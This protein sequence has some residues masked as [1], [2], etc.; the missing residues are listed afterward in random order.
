MR[1]HVD[2]DGFVR[3]PAGLVYRRLTDIQAWPTWWP[4][5]A[6]AVHRVPGPEESWSLALG[7]GPGRLRLDAVAGEWRHDQGFVLKV[8]GDLEG[9]IEFW[10]EAGHDGTIVH[11]V[12]SADTV[13][14]RALRTVKRL[15]R[16][17]RA[18]LWGFKDLVQGEVR[19]MI[20]LAQ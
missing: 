15:R 11:V 17:V 14:P 4:H 3:A 12:T 7:R 6:V 8:S 5:V 20:G 16:S 1:F 13:G 19:G 9:T 10:L 18:G 2:D